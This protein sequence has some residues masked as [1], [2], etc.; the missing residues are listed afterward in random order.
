MS[1]LPDSPAEEAA[2]WLTFASDDLMTADTILEHQDRA[3]RIASFLAQQAAEKALKAVLIEH[4][5]DVPRVHDLVAIAR[6]LPVA[7]EALDQAQLEEL[8][9]WAVEGRYPADLPEATRDEASRMVEAARSIVEAVR[10]RLAA[11]PDDAVE[12][13]YEPT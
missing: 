2:R 4:T 6:L 12:R 13:P 11:P 8:S 5:M 10:S 3:F 9:G 1:D 7:I